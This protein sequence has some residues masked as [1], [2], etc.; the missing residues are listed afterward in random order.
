MREIELDRSPFRR[1]AR[2]HLR[3][4]VMPRL[5]SRDWRNSIHGQSSSSNDQVANYSV[6][7]VDVAVVHYCDAWKIAADVAASPM[8]AWTGS[9]A[10]RM[11]LRR[12]HREDRWLRKTLDSSLSHSVDLDRN[13]AKLEQDSLEVVSSVA[14]EE[15]EVPRV[16]P[17]P[18]SA[19]M[20]AST[21]IER[22]AAHLEA[23][24]KVQS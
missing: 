18:L 11:M 7:K 1:L 22:L 17:A 10:C 6:G 23:A 13:P 2:V 3:R 12:M 9:S 8:L 16:R 21:M 15:I 19:T 5:Q 20:T 4:A 24:G 14:G